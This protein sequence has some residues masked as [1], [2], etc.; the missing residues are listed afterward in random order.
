MG[1]LSIVQNQDRL[2]SY[3]ILLITI[4]GVGFLLQT[5]FS[6]YVRQADVFTY[7]L[8]FNF[9]R[10]DGIVFN[11]DEQAWATLSP[12]WPMLIG[13]MTGAITET[14]IVVPFDYYPLFGSGLSVVIYGLLALTLYRLLR[15]E[16]F[17]RP[18]ALLAVFIFLTGQPIWLGMR[19]AD[20]LALLLILIAYQTSK[21]RLW[22]VAGILGGLAAL[23]TPS[24]I[25]G[26]LLLGIYA[27]RYERAWRYWQVVWI[28]LGIWLGY[29][30]IAH[31]VLLDGLL[32]NRQN[33]TVDALQTGVWVGLLIVAFWGIQS[34]WLAMLGMWAAAHIV[35][36]LISVGDIPQVESSVVVLVVAIVLST[37]IMQR[38][39]QAVP[40]AIAWIALYILFPVETAPA[41][42]TDIDLSDTIYIPERTDFLHDRGDAVLYAQTD[43]T[44]NV[45]RWDGT[46]SPFVREMI[47]AQDYES[48]LIALAPDFIYMNQATLNTAGID[49]RSDTLSALRY[50]REIDVQI[51]PGQREGDVFWFRDRNV[52]DFGDTIVVEEQINPDLR[53][54][55]YAI[56]RRRFSPD[57]PLR[58]R[59]DWELEDKPEHEIGLQLSLLDIFGNPLVTIF[60]TYDSV[61]WQRD[62][63]STYH[64]LAVPADTLPQVARIS[65][66]VDYRA[67][68]IGNTTLGEVVIRNAEIPP[69]NEQGRINNAILYSSSV[70]QQDNQLQVE[71]EWGVAAPLDQDYQVFVQLIPTNSP[72]PVASG[73]DAPYGGRIP[74]SYW[75]SGELIVDPHVVNLAG[76]PSGQ[77]I[78]N[79][80]FYVLE[81][82]ERLRD[83]N[84]DSLTIAQIKIEDDGTVTIQPSQ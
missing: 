75:Q 3:G 78:L 74:T 80:G 57:E 4:A 22:Y 32:A 33:I 62:T 18:T 24:G 28:P 8:A 65:F 29:A 12:L 61:T 46:H 59:F 67:A 30:F 69:D 20:P 54:V 27:L 19:S 83:D 5:Q 68:L 21:Q 53:L 44:G 11:A 50:R 70:M 52:E 31:D 55:S 56:D 64:A 26:M 17:A 38:R 15:D 34:A 72:Q 16:D 2:I 9:S 63:L 82:F 45:Y 81:T 51:D 13:A 71:L 48:L 25:L 66:A 43:L 84:G 40:I 6:D 1:V 36:S 41:L 49:F 37:W 79:V 14:T 76:V 10:G 7:R 77:Y 58:I 35:L 60:P 42:T 47:A 73:D 23:A 39:V